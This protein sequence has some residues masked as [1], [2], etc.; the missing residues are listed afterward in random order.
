MRRVKGRNLD[1]RQETTDKTDV[2]LP[3]NRVLEAVMRLLETAGILVKET[4]VAAMT[5]LTLPRLLDCRLQSLH[6]ACQRPKP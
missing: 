4:H 5:Y 3:L 6:E 1:H 2:Y